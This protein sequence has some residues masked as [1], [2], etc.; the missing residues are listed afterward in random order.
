MQT[1]LWPSETGGQR[2]ARGTVESSMLFTTHLTG[3]S[4]RSSA[5]YA[6]THFA[7]TGKGNGRLSSMTGESYPY[8]P[9]RCRPNRRG[10]AALWRLNHE[11]GRTTRRTRASSCKTNCLRGTSRLGTWVPASARSLTTS[12]ECSPSRGRLPPNWHGNWSGSSPASQPASGWASRPTTTSRWPGA[13]APRHS[14]EARVLAHPHTLTGS[15]G[16][17]STA[18][19]SQ[20][21]LLHL[22]SSGSHACRMCPRS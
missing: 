9:G 4:F 14:H 21:V 10:N 6:S 20:A 16:R 8:V 11:S 7:E 18:A 5:P 1:W 3:T 22:P 13:I 2:L 19:T 15:T 12:K 17:T